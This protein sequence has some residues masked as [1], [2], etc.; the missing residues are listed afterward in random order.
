MK[1]LGYVFRRAA[2]LSVPGPRSSVW[3]GDGVA[4]RASLEN[5][6]PRKGSASSNL[7]PSAN[8]FT[9]ADTHTLP[10]RLFRFVRLRIQHLDWGDF[11]PFIYLEKHYYI[12]VSY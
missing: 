6:R 7:A 10:L 5:W 3:R 4:E 12:T 11:Y 8:I 1:S 2:I 9:L